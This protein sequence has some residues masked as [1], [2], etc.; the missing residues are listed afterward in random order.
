MTSFVRVTPLLALLIGISLA[1]AAR[2]QTIYSW[3]TPSGDWA[4]GTNWDLGVPPDTTFDELA[5]ISNG[6]TALVNTA[7]S[8]S[9]G[10]IILGQ[11]AGQSGAVTVGNGGQ[12][13]VVFTPGNTSTGGINIG[14][15]G[16]G[17]VNVLP[18]G[19]LAARTITLGTT[20][21]SGLT[22][23]GATG[24]ATTVNVEFGTTLGRTT[25]VIGPNVNFATQAVTFQGTSV[26]VPQITAATHSPIKSTNS[27][28]LAG[29][30]RPE[31]SNGVVPAAGNK[32]NLIDAPSFTGQF[33]VDSSAAPVLPFGQV[34]Q[35][36]AVPDVTSVNGVYGQ[37]SV[38]Q[39]LV[40]NV[41]R[42]TGA[43]SINNGPSP[44]SID[45]YSIRSALGG[46]KPS[47]WSSLQDQ[48][49][50]DWRESPP[51]GS[52]N[53]L[54]ELKPTGSTSITS[55]TPRSLGNSFQL[56]V[57]TQFGT[58]LEDITFEYYSAGGVVTQGLVNYIGDKKYNNL[59]LV[60]DPTTGNARMENQSALTVAIDGY[61]VTS[62]SGSLRPLAGQW[63]SL[64]DQNVGGG[65]WRESNPTVNQLVE[66]KPT[67][68]TTMTGGL[69]FNLGAAFK[70]VASGGTQDLTFQ[71]LFPGDTEF[72]NGVVAYRA[73]SSFLPAD[74]NHDNQ[75]N[76][77][78]LTIWRSSF[79]VN[80]NGDANGDGDS[81][82]G[83]F[84]V[85]QR[86]LGMTSGTAAAAAV[87]EPCMLMLV[88][89]AVCGLTC[90]RRRA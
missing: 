35:F 10:Q 90:S 37:L 79:G 89:V 51:G 18:G 34:Y 66:L 56:P 64:D 67:A 83:D 40:L 63:N 44:V 14:Q 88:G 57:P 42:T 82:G 48:G 25:R 81:D 1:A 31:F 2:A 27:A 30:L 70:T 52:V 76:G 78:D 29:V 13:A 41:N 68:S 45:G 8:P 74:F 24:G 38:K 61:K 86:Q 75:V 7:I 84:L 71:Y 16:T 19:I 77:A 49:L 20:T 85:W 39:L 3:N 15:A 33:T 54:N 9:P 26:F 58:E 62:A 80:A 22:I 5:N 21:G 59:V 47:G 55:G 32:W 36:A 72:R 17:S 65:D 53:A 6:G 73:L 69:G 12:L 4:G 46:L 87:P 23:G 43:I 11:N 28:A 60:V 50:S